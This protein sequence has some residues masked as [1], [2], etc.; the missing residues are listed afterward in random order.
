[1]KYI[2]TIVGDVADTDGMKPIECATLESAL[3]QIQNYAVYVC[4]H[5]CRIILTFDGEGSVIETTEISDGANCLCTVL[6]YLRT[7]GFDETCAPAMG[8]AVRWL[9]SRHAIELQEL[10]SAPGGANWY[11]QVRPLYK[12]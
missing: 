6:D 8:R 4:D 10:L 12:L 5:E 2:V 11:E 1:M 3:R 7:V 9:V